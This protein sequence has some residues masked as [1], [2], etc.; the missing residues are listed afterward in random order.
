MDEEAEA[1]KRRQIEA[2]YKTPN[3]T[4]EPNEKSKFVRLSP[5]VLKECQEENNAT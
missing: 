3:K 4:G 1:Y 5:E 2:A